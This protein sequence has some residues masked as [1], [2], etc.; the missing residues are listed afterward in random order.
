M[1][2]MG[3]LAEK[4]LRVSD[5]GQVLWLEDPA[6]ATPFPTLEAAQRALAW[7]QPGAHVRLCA[8]EMRRA[9]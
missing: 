7:L 4:F 2:A 1:P 5:L 8:P 9:A 6:A 3:V